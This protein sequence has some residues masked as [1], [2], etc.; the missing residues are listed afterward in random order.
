MRYVLPSHFLPMIVFNLSILQG[1]YEST[2]AGRRTDI[3]CVK[4]NDIGCP[5]DADVN[6]LTEYCRGKLEPGTVVELTLRQALKLMPRRRERSDAYL[7][8]AKWLEREKNVKLVIT[9]KKRNYE[10]DD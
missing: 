6:A 3:A 4:E 5:F 8:L 7:A 9:S 1:D 2:E 10:T